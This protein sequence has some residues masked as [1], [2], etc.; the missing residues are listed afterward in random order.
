MG[1]GG[2][3]FKG[4]RFPSPILSPMQGARFSGSFS[5]LCVG[6]FF[7]LSL[8]YILPNAFGG[9]YLTVYLGKLGFKSFH[10][11]KL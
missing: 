9:S 2:C 8:F 10:F 3:F 4:L 7:I 11:H 6:R 5:L 1:F